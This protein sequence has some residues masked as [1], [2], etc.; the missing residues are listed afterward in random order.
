MDNFFVI[1]SPE[2]SNMTNSNTTSEKMPQSDHSRFDRQPIFVKF[3]S[4]HHSLKQ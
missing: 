4:Y 3:V 2:V 1:G